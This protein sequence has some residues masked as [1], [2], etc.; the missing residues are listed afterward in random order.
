[1]YTKLQATAI[2]A[3]MDIK[4]IMPFTKVMFAKKG[5]LYFVYDYDGSDVMPVKILKHTKYM[6]FYML[7]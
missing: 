7:Y 2:T 4:I 3:D 1:M 6:E 5:E